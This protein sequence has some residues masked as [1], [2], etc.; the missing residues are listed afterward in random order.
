MVMLVKVCLSGGGGGGRSKKKSVPL[1]KS[2][3][4]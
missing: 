2:Q 3:C 4:D 1:P